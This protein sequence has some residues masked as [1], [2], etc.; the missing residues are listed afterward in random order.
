MQE[1]G[2]SV[3]RPNNSIY[4]IYAPHSDAAGGFPPYLDVSRPYRFWDRSIAPSIN[5]AS[6]CCYVNR[7]ALLEGSVVHSQIA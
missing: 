3:K 4:P 5:F 1:L 7:F 6:Y 2:A